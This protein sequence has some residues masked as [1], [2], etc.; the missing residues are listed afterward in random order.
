MQISFLAVK[1]GEERL[2]NHRFPKVEAHA[3]TLRAA[4]KYPDL[5]FSFA[6][7]L[8]V[9]IF[10]QHGIRGWSLRFAFLFSSS[11]TF[12]FSP[13]TSPTS[14]QAQ[15]RRSSQTSTPSPDTETTTHTEYR[16]LPFFS[17]C[18]HGGRWALNSHCWGGIV[19]SK[20]PPRPRLAQRVQ[21][22]RKERRKI[23][24]NRPRRYLKITLSTTSA[25]CVGIAPS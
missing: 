11:S 4:E 16:R 13:S 22:T 19:P 7:R 20:G 25:S 17:S 24:P 10:T 1:D 6:D 23:L 3:K 15:Q 14:R 9:P 18:Q 21:T 12:F 8:V 2:T 5:N